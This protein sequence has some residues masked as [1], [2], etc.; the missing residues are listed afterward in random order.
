ME[1]DADL[2]EVDDCVEGAVIESIEAGASG[3]L[4]INLQDG[5]ILVIPDAVLI[6]VVSP[7]H[8]IQ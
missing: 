6:A 4:H 5:R 3:G 2:A 1:T 7:T 8:T